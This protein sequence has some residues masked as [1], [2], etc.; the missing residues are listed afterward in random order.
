MSPV[1]GPYWTS[2]I[3]CDGTEENLGQCEK[4]ELGM[5]TKCENQHYAGVLCYDREGIIALQ[6]KVIQINIFCISPLKHMFWELIRSASQ[7]HFL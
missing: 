5:V 6:M 1:N 3:N 4:T 7:R 2:N